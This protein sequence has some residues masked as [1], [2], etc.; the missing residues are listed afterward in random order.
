LSDHLSCAIATVAQTDLRDAAVRF[1]P[2][3]V[4]GCMNTLRIIDSSRDTTVPRHFAHF[5]FDVDDAGFRVIKEILRAMQAKALPRTPAR[6]VVSGLR[7]LLR[8][9]LERA[10]KSRLY[11]PP[12]TPAHLQLDVEQT[13]V[14]S[15]R[16]H[17]G[18]AVDRHGRRVACVDW[19]VGE[20][21]YRNIR[22]TA[23]RILKKWP[24]GAGLPRLAAVQFEQ[25]QPKPH[26]AYHPVGTCRM[27]DDDQATV[28]SDLKVRGT[29]NLFVLST[30]VF[31]SAGSANPTFSM[32]CLGDRLA[33]ELA[34]PQ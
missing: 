7:G 1:G 26:D 27:G 17:L 21:D 18:R 16:V 28:N 4:R 20:E 23:S 34:C 25:A 14:A 22:A 2:A 13:P 10:F 33:A 6:E 19:Q 8:L 3:F 29:Q 12:G 5:I 9:A 31:P 30:A 32:L 15:N 11:I 24:A